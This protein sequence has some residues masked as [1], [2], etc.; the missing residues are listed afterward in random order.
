[1]VVVTL[2]AVLTRKP[3]GMKLS[4][5][6]ILQVLVIHIIVRLT[7]KVA[8]YPYLIYDTV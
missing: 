3:I 2:T 4:K 1:M 6:D 7:S 5:R 8:K